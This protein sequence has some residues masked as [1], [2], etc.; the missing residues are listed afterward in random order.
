MK[1]LFFLLAAAALTLT[2]CDNIKDPNVTIEDG[3]ACVS[4]KIFTPPNPAALID[5]LLH[6]IENENV[7]LQLKDS[8]GVWTLEAK[9]CIKLKKTAV[10]HPSGLSNSYAS[11]FSLPA[12]AIPHPQA[13]VL[14][15]NSCHFPFNDH[16]P[17]TV[18]VSNLVEGLWYEVSMPDNY[19]LN[20]KKKPQIARA[21]ALYFQYNP[22]QLAINFQS[23]TSVSA[24]ALSISGPNTVDF[25]FNGPASVYYNFPNLTQYFLGHPSWYLPVNADPHQY[26][27]GFRA[28]PDSYVEQAYFN[29]I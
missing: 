6:G 2:A 16:E 7:H 5:S 17:I 23:S 14:G 10:L 8:G 21:T 12:P 11:I 1:K 28:Y 15:N 3:N 22:G 18:R 4:L 9:G 19:L 13:V 27:L 29:I 24:V 26:Y 20:A 25:V